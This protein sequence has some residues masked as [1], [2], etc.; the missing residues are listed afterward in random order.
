MFNKAMAV[1]LFLAPFI[2]SEARDG[3]WPG[4]DTMADVNADGR[5]DFIWYE[6]AGTLRVALSNGSTFSSSSTWS[7]TAFPTGYGIWFADVTGDGRADAISVREYLDGGAIRVIIRR[8]NGSSFLPEEEW[9]SE[10]GWSG[11]T[12]FD[13]KDVSGDGKADFIL[14]PNIDGGSGIS[15]ATSSGTGFNTRTAWTS[16]SFVAER[17]MYY[18]DVTGDG[19]ADAI[20]HNT[21][22]IIVRPS[23]GSSFGTASTWLSVGF[24]GT[25]GVWF[26]D[27]TGDGKADVIVENTDG[28]QVRASSGTAFLGSGYW[29]SSL[30][31]NLSTWV[32]DVTGDGKSDIV[33]RYYAVSGVCPPSCPTVVTQWGRVRSSDGSTFLAST[34]WY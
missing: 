6:S 32:A 31:G 33:Y 28:V 14:N 13:F 4:N 21:N 8:S 23:T 22:S 26:R 10:V 27:V 29:A 11:W 24:N 34:T 3:I 2:P 12:R 9:Y 17:N 20:A 30:G 7:S 1:A 16:T 19:I 5:D 18:E 25:K 15:V